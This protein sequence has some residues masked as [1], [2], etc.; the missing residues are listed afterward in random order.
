MDFAILE[1]RIREKLRPHTDRIGNGNFTE[2]D[3]LPGLFDLILS[4]QTNLQK[5]FESNIEQ[6][7]AH[8][9]S[10]LEKQTEILE[11]IVANQHDYKQI[12]QAQR[13]LFLMVLIVS[14]LSLLSSITAIALLLLR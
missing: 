5:V 14:I 13:K 12:A 10:T 1:S 2:H 6:S 8:H 4:N 11:L 9:Q 7:N 3:V